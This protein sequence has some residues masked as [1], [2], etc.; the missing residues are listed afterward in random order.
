MN[1]L[2]LTNTKNKFFKEDF[3]VQENGYL[4]TMHEI[5]RYGK[6]HEVHFQ[7]E[8]LESDDIIFGIILLSVIN[9]CQ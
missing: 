5:F 2:T 8:Q 3:F 1:A 7:A 6:Y 4:S 9:H